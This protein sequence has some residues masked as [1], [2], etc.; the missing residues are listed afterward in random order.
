MASEMSVRQLR[1][2]EVL[3]IGSASFEDSYILVEGLLCLEGRD[4]TRANL[5]PGT[6]IG[7]IAGTL[8]PANNEWR[9]SAYVDSVV[10]ALSKQQLLVWTQDTGNLGRASREGLRRWHDIL[11]SAMRFEDAATSSSPMGRADP[12]LSGV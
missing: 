7:T 2:D 6:I 9:V 12:V 5:Q 11:T 8:R 3:V 10:Y 1:A 4:G